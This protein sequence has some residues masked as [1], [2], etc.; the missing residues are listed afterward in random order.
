MLFLITSITTVIQTTITLARTSAAVP[1]SVSQP[2]SSLTISWVPD[3]VLGGCPTLGDSLPV[4]ETDMKTRTA[5]SLG[6]CYT[7]GGWKVALGVR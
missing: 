1:E 3:T 4:E 5:L 7:G 6:T 2:F